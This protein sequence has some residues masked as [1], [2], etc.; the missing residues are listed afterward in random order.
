MVPQLQGTGVV[1][2]YPFS[3][4]IDPNEG[5]DQGGSQTVSGL[6]PLGG[7]FDDGDGGA[8]SFARGNPQVPQRI[9]T[10]YALKFVEAELYL[11]GVVP[12]DHRAA[13]EEAIWASFEKVNQIAA[14]VSSPLMENAD[15]QEYV[16]AVLADYDTD[17]ETGKLEH[18]MTQKWIA[19]FGFGP[20]MFTDFRRTGF[21][22][23]HDAN[24]D[25]LSFTIRN[26]EFPN[27]FPWPTANLQVNSNAPA[28][29]LVT[30]PEAKP[31]WMN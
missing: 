19:S 26:R 17:D 16:D 2:I 6:Y 8:S 9:L 22:V 24:T 5:Y 18:I 29:K 11:T 27:S 20:D 4:N 31:F 7:E 14:S 21:P 3:L 25:N 10:Y 30:S 23:L 15:I 12:G 1:A 28:Q 13:L